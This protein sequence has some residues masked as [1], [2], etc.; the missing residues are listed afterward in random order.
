MGKTH[1]SS[2]AAAGEPGTTAAPSSAFDV[3]AH[4]PP[5]EGAAEPEVS[6][7]ALLRRAMEQVKVLE[8]KNTELKEQTTA[9][10]LK[11]ALAKIQSLAAEHIAFS[12]SRLGLNRKLDEHGEAPPEQPAKSHRN[13]AR[14]P[15]AAVAGRAWL[16]H[17]S[18]SV[19]EWA[20][21]DKG[22]DGD[23][24]GGDGRAGAGLTC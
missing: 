13:A 1:D 7:E 22:S 16:S 9:D 15:A 11:L 14:A 12:Q 5:D 6:E 19:D 10:R 23:D 2:S 18:T 17:L 8:G 24:G 3:E 20:G 4:V 21:C